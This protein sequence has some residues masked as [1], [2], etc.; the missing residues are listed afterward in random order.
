MAVL[1]TNHLHPA[2]PWLVEECAAVAQRAGVGTVAAAAPE[3]ATRDDKPLLDVLTAIRHRTTLD[4]AAAH[5]LLLPNSEHR[6]H[7]ERTLR[8]RLRAHPEAF[9]NAARIAAEC[10][11][12]LDFSDVRF[13]GFPVPDGET[14]FSV[15]YAL[16]QDSVQ[17]KYH[18]MTRAVAS[19]LQRELDV[20]EKTGL[21]EFFLITWDIMRYAREHAIPG[22]GRGSAADSIVAYLLG[23]T[24]V[25][26]VAH[27]LLFERFL[28]E[29]HQGTPDIDIDFSTDHREQVLQYVYDKYGADRTGMVANVVTFRPRMAIRQVGAAMGFPETVVDRLARG[30]DGWYMANLDD[31]L[32]AAG[33]EDSSRSSLPWRQLLDVLR[34]IE[35]TPRHLSIHV[36]G[37]LVTGE[38]LVDVVPVERATMP[39]RVVVQ[40]D[41]DDVE[42]L[43][44]IKMDLL[45][46]RTLSAIAECLDLIEQT[47]GERP[48]LDALPLDDPRVYDMI[49]KV[50]TIGLFQIESRAQQ[51][52]LWQSQPRCFNDLIVQV[53]IIRPGPIQGDAVHPYLRRR[54]GLEP[55]TYP[56]P[57]LEPILAE[58]RGVILYQEQILRIVMEVADYTAGEADRFRRAMNRHRSRLEMEELRDDFIRRCVEHGLGEPVAAQVF[59]SVAGFAEFGFCK[60]HAAAFAR[61]AYETAWLRLNYPAHYTCALLN[62]QPMGFY[63]PSVLVDDARAHGVRILPVDVTRS[64]A[65]CTVEAEQP[66]SEMPPAGPHGRL[67]DTSAEFAVRLGFAYVRRLGPAARAA[68]EDAINAGANRSV[69]E[70]WRHTLLPRSAME[71]LVQVGAFDAV[72]GG[73]S[74]RQMLWQLKEIEESLPARRRGTATAATPAEGVASSGPPRGSGAIAGTRLGDA[75]HMP[76]DTERDQPAPLV[77]LPAPP[78]E[79]PPMD[80]RTRVTT[81]Y[82]LTQVST[83]P[84]LVS[85]MRERLDAMGC[86]PLGKV[87]ELADGARVRVAG[88]VI[89]RQAPMS[90]SG[91]RFFTL[92]DGEAHLDLVFRPAVAQRTRE[93]A[94]HPLLMVDGTLQV[95]S[96]RI[97]VVVASVTALDSD[98]NP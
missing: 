84:H 35:G 9:D 29:D 78:P 75:P 59:K 39:G 90:A 16:C 13:P 14:P 7:D 4:K 42:D 46:L 82:S 67:L 23:I 21:A 60:S 79:L 89:T 74:R 65:R 62:A 3:H 73:L 54:Q 91:F 55:V 71:N 66:G 98:G 24:R 85:F 76:R 88:L 95:E 64:R 11:V 10:A 44:L 87:R 47:T 5:G 37:M 49:C 51:Q 80:E 48:D 83:G 70:F 53:A 28:H 22:Q 58:T 50:D 69:A 17:R 86:I 32:R 31:T 77:P 68:C 45:G 96:G 19:R 34:R 18:P 26:P 12:S 97:N 2:D 94:R 93:A 38:P 15:L 41:K 1:L 57:K 36:G 81:E 52:S 20:I 56:H 6:L 92:T 72:A 25:D 8:A 40:F 30:A 33:V 43:G 63:H 61:T 27:D